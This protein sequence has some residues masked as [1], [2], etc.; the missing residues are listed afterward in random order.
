MKSASG[1]F[2]G[3]AMILLAAVVVVIAVFVI[4]FIVS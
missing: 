1:V 4:G 3:L 2:A